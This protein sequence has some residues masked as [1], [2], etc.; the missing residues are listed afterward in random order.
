MHRELVLKKIKEWKTS[1]PNSHKEKL[2]A[3]RFWIA[4]IVRVKASPDIYFSE[5]MN[6]KSM[7]STSNDEHINRSS[8][9]SNSSDSSSNNSSSSS[10]SSG[11]GG[12]FGG[13]GSS[14]SW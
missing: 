11:R 5:K 3:N 2:S 9:W 8:D 12:N 6:P 1:P 14:G 4:N 13:G 7:Y 10:S